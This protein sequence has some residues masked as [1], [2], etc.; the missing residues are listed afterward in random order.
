MSKNS[1]KAQIDELQKQKLAIDAFSRKIKET[2]RKL[3]DEFT[4]SLAEKELHREGARLL[5][6]ITF[7][8]L[9]KN[10]GQILKRIDPN[11]NYSYEK[12]EPL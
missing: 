6:K 2:R 5:S 9:R 10:L 3:G 4:S 8:N 7:K 11:K 12:R 1:K